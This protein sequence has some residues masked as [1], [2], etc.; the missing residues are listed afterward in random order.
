M[1]NFEE[2]LARFKPS[3]EIEQVEDTIAN[4]DIADVTDLMV[5]FLREQYHQTNA[6]EEQ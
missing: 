5:E 6:A 4:R 1:L 2:E 3:K